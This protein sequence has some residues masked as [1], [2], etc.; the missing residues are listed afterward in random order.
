MQL[1]GVAGMVSALKKNT[2]S[3]S[4]SVRCCTVLAG[5]AAE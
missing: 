3:P 2:Y 1:T 5:V 4:P